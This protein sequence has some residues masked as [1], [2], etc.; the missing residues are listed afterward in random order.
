MWVLGF[1]QWWIWGF[2]CSG[3]LCCINGYSDPIFLLHYIFSN[4]RIWLL[5]DAVSY[6]RVESVTPDTL[7]DQTA[8]KIIGLCLEPENCTAKTYHLCVSVQKVWAIEEVT[9][10]WLSCLKV[11]LVGVSHQSIQGCFVFS[12]TGCEKKRQP[13]Y[14]SCNID[15]C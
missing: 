5:T 2:C 15:V 13:R 6:S 12:N 10:H 4:I 14:V 9:C 11:A 8:C 7:N 1:L 3:I